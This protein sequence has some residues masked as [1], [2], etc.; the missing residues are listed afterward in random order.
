MNENE[1]LF[2]EMVKRTLEVMFDNV[3]VSETDSVVSIS[4]WDGSEKPDFRQNNP[5]REGVQVS[6][7]VGMTDDHKHSNVDF[8]INYDGIRVVNG[9]KLDL[10]NQFVVADTISVLKHQ[11]EYWWA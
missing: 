8:V 3:L 11:L 4:G 1:S 7:E 2:A 10:Y 6:F 5:E 9:L